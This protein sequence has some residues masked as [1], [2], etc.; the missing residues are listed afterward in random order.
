MK[1]RDSEWRKSGTRKSGIH[2]NVQFHAD[3][4]AY[5]SPQRYLWGGLKAICIPSPSRAELLTFLQLDLFPT[6]L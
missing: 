1:Q 5:I 6:L 4:L 3:P 2:L